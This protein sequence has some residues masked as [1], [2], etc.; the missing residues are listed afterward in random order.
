VK[1][2]LEFDQKKKDHAT[3]VD[4]LKIFSGELSE[5]WGK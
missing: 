3:D 1:L 5:E 2:S 4:N